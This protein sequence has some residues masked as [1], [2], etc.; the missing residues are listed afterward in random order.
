MN[1]RSIKKTALERAKARYPNSQRKAHYEFIRLWEAEC[2]K[3]TA[4]LLE[5]RDGGKTEMSKIL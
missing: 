3:F 1:P 4:S 2:K 5:Q